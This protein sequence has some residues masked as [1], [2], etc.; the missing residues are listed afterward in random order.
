[1]AYI[2]STQR[3][4]LTVHSIDPLPFLCGQ[5]QESVSFH[6]VYSSQDT[7]TYADETGIVGLGT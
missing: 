5:R 7:N 6:A 4:Q 1:M 3:T 2:F